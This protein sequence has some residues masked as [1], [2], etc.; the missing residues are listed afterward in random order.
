MKKLLNTLYVTTPETYLAIDRE[1]IVIRKDEQEIGRFPLHNLESV[2]TF[3]YTG[4]SPALMGACAKRNIGL[5]FMSASGHFQARVVGESQ[6]NVLLRKKQYR[7]SDD[8]KSSHDI[9]QNM[10]LGKLYN[11]RKVLERAIRDHPMRVDADALKAA[12]NTLQECIASARASTR[13]EQLRGYEG[14]GATAYFGVLDNLI[15]QQKDAF[16]FHGRNRRPPLDNVNAMLSFLYTLLAHDA[17][18]ALSAVGLDPYVGFLHRDRP[19]RISLGLDLME[20][21]RPVMVDRMVISMINKNEVKGGGFTAR[22]NGAVLMSDKTRN[23]ILQAW[24]ARKR[25]SITH[26]FLKEK[27]SWGLVPYA[28]AMLLARSLRGDIDA[29]PPFLWK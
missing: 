26:P 12:S 28:Q 16:Y 10:I 11:S 5:C 17:S 25:E 9:A 24:Q 15:L 18:A 1:N 19:G 27:L 29:Y 13:L 22:E 7:V 20:E 23:A 8:E 2:V 21:L 3:G 4:A 6:G 14:T